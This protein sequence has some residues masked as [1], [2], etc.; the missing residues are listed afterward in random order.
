M[1]MVNPLYSPLNLRGDEGG[2]RLR[3]RSPYRLGLKSYSETR[4]S[5][6]KLVWKPEARNK[7][8]EYRESLDEHRYE[9]RQR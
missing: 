1:K 6:K 3:L 2:L 9:L 8:L 7:K 4:S 5:V